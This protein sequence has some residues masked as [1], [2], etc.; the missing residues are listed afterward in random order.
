[1]KY[2][3]FL[4]FGL[5]LE[6]RGTSFESLDANAIATQNGPKIWFSKQMEILMLRIEK[7]DEFDSNEKRYSLNALRRFASTVLL[8]PSNEFVQSVSNSIENTRDAVDTMRFDSIEMLF[9]S[10]GLRLFDTLQINI[11]EEEFEG[12]LP[13]PNRQSV[14]ARLLVPLQAYGFASLV[15]SISSRVRNTRM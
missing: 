10:L 3:L 9:V 4:S 8:N 5:L 7:S 11:L 12:L 2:I 15:A 6:S 1:M 14:L 13:D